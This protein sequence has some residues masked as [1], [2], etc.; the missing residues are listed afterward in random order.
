MLF[1]IYIYISVEF[2]SYLIRVASKTNTEARKKQKRRLDIIQ[3]Y[4]LFPNHFNNFK[5]SLMKEIKQ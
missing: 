3:S 5:N 2:G 4:S 1:V